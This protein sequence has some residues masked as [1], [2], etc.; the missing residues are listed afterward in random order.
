MRWQ[1]TFWRA[2][3]SLFAFSAARLE[4]LYTPQRLAG[5]WR[6]ARF[7]GRAAQRITLPE[8]AIVEIQGGFRIAVH[9]KDFLQREIYLY[10]EWEPHVCEVMRRLLRS[11]DVFVDVG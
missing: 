5:R 2:K 6:I 9:T 4:Y 10:H 8:Q 3:K 7:I 11:G 1:Y